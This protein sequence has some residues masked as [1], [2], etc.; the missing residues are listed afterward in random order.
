MGTSSARRD[1][2]D[3]FARGTR[4]TDDELRTRAARLR[5][6]YNEFL[7]GSDWGRFD[8]HSLIETLG[9]YLDLNEIDARWVAQISSRNFC[10]VVTTWQTFKSAPCRIHI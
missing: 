7:A 4:A 2:L 8:A 3:A 10:S 1:D 6:D 5:S 9:R